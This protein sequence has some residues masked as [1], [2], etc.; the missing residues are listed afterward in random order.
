[1]S[2]SWGEWEE[3]AGKVVDKVLK[4]LEARLG[5]NYGPIEGL[6]ALRI[7]ELYGGLTPDELAK[8]KEMPP[9]AF[10]QLI[11]E[12]IKKHIEEKTKAKTPVPLELL[13]I[14]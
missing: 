5:G 7:I 6:D 1:M 2:V 12:K 13:A 8:L 10:R 9:D 14:G 11:E 3:F 4:N